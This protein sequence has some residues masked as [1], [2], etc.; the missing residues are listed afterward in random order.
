[1]KDKPL[2]KPDV[3]RTSDGGYEQAF[4]AGFASV[5]AEHGA[6]TIAI[7]EQK[8]GPIHGAIISVPEAA[9]FDSSDV[10]FEFNDQSNSCTGGEV[11]L[12]VSTE[13]LIIEFS[14]EAEI[15]ASRLSYA[16]EA[17]PLRDPEDEYGFPL[18]RLVV[19]LQLSPAQIGEIAREV[20]RVTRR[21]RSS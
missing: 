10:Y 11:V 14:A 12:S 3:R 5:T 20:E 8:Y 17:D 9:S 2:Y 1:M 13:R 19:H 4:T 6:R 18:R 21:P 16:V 15:R 7:A